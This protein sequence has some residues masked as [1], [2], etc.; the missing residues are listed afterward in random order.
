MAFDDARAPGKR[1]AGDD[2]LAVVVDAC[3][4]GVEAGKVVLPNGVE[5]LREPF[6]LA[7][8]EH[9]CPVRA[10][11]SGTILRRKCSISVRV[12]GRLRIH[13]EAARGDGVFA[14][15]GCGDMRFS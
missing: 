10:S 5:P 11:N 9:P 1:E 6:A 4:E 2:G 15:T 12:S 3:G 13:L 14:V 8:G 7:L